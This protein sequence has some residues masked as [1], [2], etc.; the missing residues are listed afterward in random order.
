MYALR[1][2]CFVYVLDYIITNTDFK[3]KWNVFL[4]CLFS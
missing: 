3:I 2:D 1:L 4:G